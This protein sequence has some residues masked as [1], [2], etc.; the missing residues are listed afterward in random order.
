MDWKQA[1]IQCL[2]AGAA[3]NAAKRYYE[4]KAALYYHHKND[5]YSCDCGPRDLTLLY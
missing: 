3:E 4:E 1:G 2:I 5:C